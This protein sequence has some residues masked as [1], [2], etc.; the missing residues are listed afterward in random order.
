MDLLFKRY[1]SPFLFMDKYLQSG[2]FNEFVDSFIDTINEERK[3]K[4]NWEFYL[5]RVL[6]KSF[7][8]FMEAVEVE[9]ENQNMTE[10][11]VETTI[12]NSMNILANF[13]PEERGEN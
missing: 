3:H 12:K 5:H 7:S 10:A 2:C 13:N 8:E 9:Q 1:A 11:D 6:D 4:Y